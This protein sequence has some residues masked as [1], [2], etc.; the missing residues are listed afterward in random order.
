MIKMP[1]FLR[2]WF[3][4][5]KLLSVI[6]DQVD[7]GIIASAGEACLVHVYD[8]PLQGYDYQLYQKKSNGS[9]TPYLAPDTIMDPG[10]IR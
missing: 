9:I 7:L 6:P 3:A 2:R 5:G 1:Q 8:S 4:S 10:L